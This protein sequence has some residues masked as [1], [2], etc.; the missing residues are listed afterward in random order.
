MHEYIPSFSV[1]L[2]ISK[3]HLI[4]FISAATIFIFTATIK[5]FLY[6]WALVLS[7]S[8]VLTTTTEI[9]LK[10]NLD[11]IAPLP[12]LFP[13]SFIVLKINANSVLSVT[14]TFFPTFAL[15]TLI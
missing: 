1:F 4:L 14:S 5:A 11:H 3:I 7:L 6:F 9:F 15:L 13:E 2:N 10:H 8:N 12:E